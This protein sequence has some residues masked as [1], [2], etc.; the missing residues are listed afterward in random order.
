MESFRES[1]GKTIVEEL[2]T[3]IR[4]NKVYL[5]EV[6]G[7]IGDGDHGINMSKGFTMA[8]DRMKEEDIGLRD[9][10]KTLGQTLVDGPPVRPVLPEDG[11]KS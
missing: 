2:V 5:I 6:D 11:E 7:A 8:W 3:V 1:E 10:L 4:K 9:G